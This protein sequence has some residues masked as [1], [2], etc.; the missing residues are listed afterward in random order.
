MIYKMCL[1]ESARDLSFASKS[2]GR[3]FYRGA[4]ERTTSTHGH[5]RYYRHKI[6]RE[7]K[8]D[9][10][11]TVLQPVILG[12][13]KDIR[14]EAIKLLYTQTFHFSNA[15]AFQL[16]FARISPANR[17]LLK[18]IVIKGWTDYKFSRSKGVHHVFS[19]LT[20]AT[21]VKSI[22]LD[23]HVWSESDTP[24]NRYHRTTFTGN[25]S[26]LWRDIE[27]WADAIDAAQ[28][29]GAAKAALK[30]TKVCFGSEKEIEDEDEIV[31]KR[32]KEFMAQMKFSEK[33]EQ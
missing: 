17:M 22:L 32:E 23:R 25:P 1:V 3:D 14:D 18:N 26:G 15:H 5:H 10:N 2:S 31:E 12:I 19:L 28:G 6:K 27:Y 7:R 16:W 30:F 9:G 29:K 4:V 11:R 21:N 20:S 8:S 24:T 13:N 33:A